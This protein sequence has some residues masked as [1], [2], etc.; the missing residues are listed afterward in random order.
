[1]SKSK[2]NYAISLFVLVSIIYIHGIKN[3]ISM[4]YQILKYINSFLTQLY[5]T[6][7]LSECF[8]YFIT[9]PIVGIILAAIG[10]PRGREGHIIGKILYFALGYLVCTILDLISK[11]IF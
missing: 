8:K 7:I 2:T 1:M 9:F 11:F 5:N 3:T 6:S 4:F 10:S